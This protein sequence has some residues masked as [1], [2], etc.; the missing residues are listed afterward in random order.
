MASVDTTIRKQASR[1]QAASPT[2]RRASWRAPAEGQPPQAAVRPV[3]E[4]T[5]QNYLGMPFGR[6]CRFWAAMRNGALGA[7]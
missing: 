5:K 3:S 1:P 6:M 2:G 7:P 4:K